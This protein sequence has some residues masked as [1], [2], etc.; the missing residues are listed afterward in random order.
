MS[1]FE[2]KLTKL[3]LLLVVTLFL[4]LGLLPFL[5]KGTYWLINNVDTSIY[6]RYATN[7]KFEENVFLSAEIEEKTGI[8]ED[9]A[10]TINDLAEVSSIQK[11]A[12]LIA[13]NREEVEVVISNNEKYQKHLLSVGSSVDDFLDW[14]EKTAALDEKI[15][16]AC[17]YLL[18]LL[19]SFIMVVV[20]GFRKLFY[21]CAGITYTCAMLSMFTDG[22]SD[23]LVAN[24][25][26]FFA[27]M[28]LD[29]FTYRDM[30]AWK[31]IVNQAFKESTLTFIIF[32]TVVQICQSNKKEKFD[33]NCRYIFFSME[34][35]C[36]YLEQFEDTS[37]KYIAR[38][39]LPSADV[40]KLCKKKIKKYTKEIKKK[41]ISD[42]R[43]TILSAQCD[44]FKQL[45]R[46]LIFFRNNNEKHSTKEYI[47]YLRQVQSL[48]HR[49]GISTM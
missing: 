37:D 38:M 27:K 17:I 40:L 15:S 33:K 3:A 44:D 9:L 30:E 12:Y 35:Q 48:M 36:S 8:I 2:E 14:S 6:V 41:R 47:S 46:M 28:A 42:V 34:I 18:F 43:R 31:L 39:V 23:Y 10:E 24:L 20:F 16:M 45:D 22:I 32:D 19:I 21:V 25:L 11:F 4:T 49:L 26:S 5:F 13:E 7:E 29:V 1:V